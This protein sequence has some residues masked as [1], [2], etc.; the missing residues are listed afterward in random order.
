MSIRI[1]ADSSSDLLTLENADFVPVP[2]K[3]IIGDQVFWDD[4]NVNLT[5]HWS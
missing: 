3:V 5:K 1:V 4:A 2:L